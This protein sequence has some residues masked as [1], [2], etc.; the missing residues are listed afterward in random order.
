MARIRSIKPTFFK[1]L[2]VSALP[3]RARLTWLGLWTQCDDHGR[4]QDIQ[5]LIK[6]ELWPLDDVS[7]RDVAEDLE[8]LTDHGRIVRYTVG[9]RDY[10]AVQNWHHHQSINRPGKPK[11]PAPPEP[12]SAPEP[13]EQNHCGLCWQL[14]TDLST[15]EGSVSAHGTLTPGREGIKEG[16]GRD[17]RPRAS[18]PPPQNP[19]KLPNTGPPPSSPSRAMRLGAEGDRPAEGSNPPTGA[20]TTGN[21]TRVTFTAPTRQLDPDEPTRTALPPTQCTRHINDPNPPNCGPCADA[22]RSHEAAAA[23]KRQ[24][25]ADAPKCRTH[26]GEL[27]HNCRL[28]R[29]DQLAAQESR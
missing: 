28:C 20:G 19:D 12:I 10:L 3:L 9:G 2:D 23:A 7:L 4:F 5:R 16:K 22:R 17:A 29:A 6:A 26:R 18:P 13:G 15:R 1:S 14:Y 24:R 11:Y 21:T 27:A 25:V 8:V